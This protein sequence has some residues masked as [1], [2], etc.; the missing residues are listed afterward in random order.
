MVVTPLTRCEIGK[1]SCILQL[2]RCDQFLVVFQV[3]TLPAHQGEDDAQKLSGYGYKSLDPLHPFL[4]MPLVMIMHDATLTNRAERREEEQFPQ[5]GTPSFR[6]TL[7]PF[8]LAGADFKEVKAS[9]LEKLLGA[10]KLVEVSH[11]ADQP[12][13]GYLADPFHGEDQA[14]VRDIFQM[15]GHLAF[16]QADQVIARFYGGKH[17]LDFEGN[18][19]APLP[20]ANRMLRRFIKG[21]RLCAAEFALAHSLQDGSQGLKPLLHNILRG[22]TMAQKVLG[23]LR[24]YPLH[25]LQKFRKAD[26]NHLLKLV[27]KGGAP[28]YR[29]LSRLGKPSQLSGGTL[30]NY[31]RKAVAELDDVGYDLGVFQIG[32]G[33]RIAVQLLQFLRV[34]RINLHEPDRLFLQKVQQR[35]GIGT[36]RFKSNDDFIQAFRQPRFNNAFPKLFKAGAV[37]AKLKGLNLASVG[38]AAVP[39]VRFLADIKGDYKGFVV[40]R[41][42]LF[43]FNLFHGYTPFV[44]GITNLRLVLSQ[45]RSIAFFYNQPLGLSLSGI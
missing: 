15:P 38:A 28:F 41:F 9:M 32:L 24:F 36:G 1:S 3:F 11:F 31:H 29:P 6:D 20:D 13:G 33:R 12:C 10:V 35:L 23:A 37:V 45:E 30:W 5:L 25:Y 2:L 27:E 16:K 39:C 19:Y 40:D 14:A 34:H 8:V 7:V 21:L 44:L 22:R 18:A 4:E 42:K 17:L 43:W 26:K